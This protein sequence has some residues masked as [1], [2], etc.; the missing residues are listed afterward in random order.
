[1]LFGH[2]I[3]TNNFWCDQTDVA[4]KTKNTGQYPFGGAPAIDAWKCQSDQCF[5]F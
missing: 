3:K 5:L 2:F 1:M 4:A